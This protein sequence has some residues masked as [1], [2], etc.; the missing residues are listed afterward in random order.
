[1]GQTITII[2]GDSLK[3]KGDYTFEENEKAKKVISRFVRKQKIDKKAYMRSTFG[4]KLVYPEN[5]VVFPNKAYLQKSMNGQTF[6]LLP[7]EKS[8]ASETRD[9]WIALLSF[10][11]AVISTLIKHNNDFSHYN[12]SLYVFL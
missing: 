3:Q 12:T 10:L 7:E 4:Y 11:F 5:G 2:Y 6:L 8:I 1:M 9:L